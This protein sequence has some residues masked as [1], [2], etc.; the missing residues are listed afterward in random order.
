[1]R[2]MLKTVSAL[3]A[4]V[5][6]VAG[7]SAGPSEQCDTCHGQNG[8]STDSAVPTIAGF[9][10]FVVED[11]LLAFQDGARP[12]RSDAFSEDAADDHCAL[13]KTLDADTIAKLAAHYSGQP[14]VP[15][16]QEVDAD[17]VAAGAALH[18]KLCERCHT[19]GGSLADDDASILAGQWMPYLKQTFADFAS[20]E[21]DQP[22]SMK[23]K[24][25]P[26]TDEEVE[27]LVHFYGSTT[28]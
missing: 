10:E 28:P 19:E 13:V 16:T 14:F 5:A 20:G 15:A 11:Y 3:T 8:V 6:L 23:K 24:M 27:A 12:C 9:S 21:R 26:L 4:T 2:T 18:D 22:K 7:A 25:D 17:K 1:M